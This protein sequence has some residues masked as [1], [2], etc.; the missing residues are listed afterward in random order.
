ME[1]GWHTSK[2]RGGVLEDGRC[3]SASFTKLAYANP[4][5]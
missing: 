5:N 2:K 1:G 3:A 4:R